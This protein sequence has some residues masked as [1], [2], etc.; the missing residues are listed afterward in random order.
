MTQQSSP[1]NPAEAYEHFIAQTIFVPWT[2]DILRRAS[3]QRGSR[4]LDL[5][6][7]TGIVARQVAPLLGP[8]GKLTGLDISPG[9]LDVARRVMPAGEPT[10][11]WQEGSG[12]Q[13]PF[14]DASFD[15][16][17]CQQGLQFFPDHQA[18]MN[19][20]HRVL[21]PE[22]RAVVAVWRDM[23]EMPFMQAVN[24]VVA[25]HLGDAFAAP[26]A[27]GDESRL[28]TLATAA[29]FNRVEVQRAEL[30][31]RI[32]DYDSVVPMM[33]HG[34]AAVLPQFAALSPEDR[35]VIIE[36]MNAELKDAIQPL[37]DGDELVYDSA[38][39]VLKAER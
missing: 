1:Q 4:V 12:T 16:V 30:S 35:Q 34:A 23:G 39:N 32:R 8:D 26:F 13:M 5:A 28:G 6:C 7:G 19:E 2:V 37:I 27:L 9:M 22:G 17:L 3:P 36:R 38:V 24:S 10:V 15:L 11:E 21:A 25:D 33:L 29:G 18:G 20:I 14:P 31:I